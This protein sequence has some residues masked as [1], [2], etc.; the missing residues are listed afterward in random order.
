MPT[1]NYRRLGASGLKLSE[2]SFGSGVTYG[3]QALNVAALLDDDVMVR[4]DA[5]LART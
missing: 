2:L 5:A 3:N 4:I 1:M